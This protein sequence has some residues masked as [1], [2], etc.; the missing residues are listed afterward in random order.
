MTHLLLAF[1]LSMAAAAPV[2]TL[3]R[4]PCFGSCPNY[5]LEIFADGRVVYEGKDS[6]KRKGRVQGR[7]PKAAVQQLVR[8][9]NRINYMR[10]DDEYTSEGPNCPEYWTDSASAITS[11]NWKGRQKTIHHYYGCRGARVL[12]QLTA[13]ENKIDKV[14]NTKRWVK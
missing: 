1:T 6:V 14:A 3:E 10:L 9:F 2:I 13:L 8:E 11:L 4:T 7:I 5:K 12:D